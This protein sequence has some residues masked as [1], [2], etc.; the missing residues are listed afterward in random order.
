MLCDT[1]MI[2][3]LLVDDHAVFRQ[4][5]SLFL[6]HQPDIEVVAQAGTLAEARQTMGGLD[7]I[8]LDIGL[9]DGNGFELIGEL[10]DL[11]SDVSVL[12]LSATLD[13]AYPE[14]ALE[15]GA[16]AMLSKV[17]TPMRITDEIRRMSTTY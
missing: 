15:A 9:P 12:V 16:D 14:R 4:A 7:V 17:H 1:A 5:L 2:R 11:K 10:R 8:V 13:P 6:D 3:V